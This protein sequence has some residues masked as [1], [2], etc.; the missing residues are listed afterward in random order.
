MNERKRDSVLRRIANILSHRLLLSL[1]LL[2]IQIGAVVGVI[3][4]GAQYFVRFYFACIA[5]S[6]LVVLRIVNKQGHP[7][8]KIVWILAIL[9]FPRFGGMF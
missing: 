9:T 5:L 4:V 3:L 6:L 8:Y 7:D 1:L 2:T